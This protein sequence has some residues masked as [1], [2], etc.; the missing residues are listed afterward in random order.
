MERLRVGDIMNKGVVVVSPRD[1]VEKAAKLMARYNIGSVIV[2][3]KGKAVGILTERDIVRRVVSKNRDSRKT[4]VKTVM[5]HPLKVISARSYV[6][7]AVKAFKKYNIKRL[8][9][10]NDKGMLIGIL[11]DSEIISTYPAYIN[12]IK[13]SSILEGV[14]L[15]YP[16]NEGPI[17]GVCEECGTYSDD[18]R[19]VN[20]KLLCPVCREE[21]E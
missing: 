15:S 17:S 12:L 3:D 1:T 20:G 8:P 6:E 5:S 9:V 10:V 2:V 4:R 11:T 21:E 7:D 13:E 18:L 14:P 19:W 16:T